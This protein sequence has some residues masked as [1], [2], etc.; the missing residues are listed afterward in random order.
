MGSKSMITFREYKFNSEF[1]FLY[2]QGKK[3]SPKIEFIH[4]HNCLEIAVCEK[5]DMVWNMENREHLVHPGEMCLLP[6]FF[7]HA[8]FFP[9]SSGPD[10]LCHY[11]FFNPEEL[12][13]PFF[14]DGLP[15]EFLWYRYY[16]F[17]GVLSEKEFP[18]LFALLQKM[19]RE[20]SRKDPFYR[21]EICGL[22]EYLIIELSRR[23]SRLTPRPDTFSTSVRSSV[24]P[25]VSYIDKHYQQ[26]IQP[27][28]LAHLCG[29][30][31][32]RLMSS[33][34]EALG[35]T[36]LQYIRQVRVQ[37]A[38]FLLTRTE[39]SILDIAYAVGF[40]SVSSFNRSFLE[41]IGKTPLTFRNEKR[42]IRKDQPLYAPYT[43]DASSPADS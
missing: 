29:M 18:D 41:T 21:H 37:K 1:P 36:P 23:F 25:A 7:T 32:R 19:I 15:Q 28:L 12:L 39:D 34:R 35:K 2:M 22:A 6:P 10:V 13:A 24:F 33:F 5:G 40:S 8:S 43:E 14:P 3:P 42:S 16:G 17:P 20:I 11:L 4:F 27:S 26:E 30:T 31:N 38:C 9:V